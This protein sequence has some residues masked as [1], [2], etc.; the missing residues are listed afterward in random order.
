MLQELGGHDGADGVPAEVLGPGRAA[1][2]AVEAGERVGAARFQR[3][4]QHVAI[5]HRPSILLAGCEAV[6]MD[7]HLVVSGRRPAASRCR[8]PTRATAYSTT[9]HAISDVH[10]RQRLGVEMA[11]A[12][13]N[14]D[15]VINHGST[16]EAAEKPATKSTARASSG[17]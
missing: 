5:R 6:A 4:A 1:A 12:L 11:G 7:V 9:H 14:V 17:F 15:A 16:V 3:A 8:S 2:V 10:H 13:E